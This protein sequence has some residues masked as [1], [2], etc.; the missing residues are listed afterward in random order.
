MQRAHSVNVVTPREATWEGGK[1]R[2]VNTG[3]GED[4]YKGTARY[5]AE[6]GKTSSPSKVPWSPVDG[7]L[8]SDGR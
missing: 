8:R 5:S 4:S 6:S 7:S 3:A 2:Q 1:G